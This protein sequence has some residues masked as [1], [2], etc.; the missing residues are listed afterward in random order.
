MDIVVQTKSVQL[1]DDTVLLVDKRIEQ[2]NIQ[3]R[4][5][6]WVH[7]SSTLTTWS[8]GQTFKD[9]PLELYNITEADQGLYTC[10]IEYKPFRYHNDLWNVTAARWWIG[11]LYVQSITPAEVAQIV[12]DTAAISLCLFVHVQG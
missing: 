5:V 1:W 2:W 3:M 11:K 7:E 12:V 10:E 4:A 6:R 9:I 8:P